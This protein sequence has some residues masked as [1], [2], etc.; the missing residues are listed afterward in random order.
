MCT[1][2]KS[3]S[4]TGTFFFLFF[5]TH[6]YCLVGCLSMIVWTHAVLGVSYACVV[7]LYLHLFSTIEHVSHGKA[8]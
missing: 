7:H 1:M 5:N 2:I 4:F 6:L 8:L 3:L